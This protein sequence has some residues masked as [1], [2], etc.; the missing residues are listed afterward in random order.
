MAR[1]EM[2]AKEKGRDT[3]MSQPLTKETTGPELTEKLAG[4]KEPR[5]DRLTLD[6]HRALGLLLKCIYWSQSFRVPR[7]GHLNVLREKLQS[8]FHED[9][10]EETLHGDPYFGGRWPR[11]NELLDDIDTAIEQLKSQ[12]ENVIKDKVPE[13][14][15]IRYL[16]C[17]DELEM[18]KLRRRRRS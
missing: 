16:R 9:Y 18:V 6:E 5:A 1:K 3:P 13:K 12:V 17:L 11:D 7:Q 15:F 2:T 8:I 10:L 14:V 4:G